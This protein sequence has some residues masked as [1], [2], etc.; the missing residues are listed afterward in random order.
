MCRAWVHY[1]WVSNEELPSWLEDEVP[2]LNSDQTV[3][4]LF[5]NGGRIDDKFFFLG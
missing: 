1:G 2:H 4:G 5:H 3:T